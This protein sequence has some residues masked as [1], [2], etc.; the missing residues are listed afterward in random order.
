MKTPVNK[1]YLRST[2]E[3]QNT[4]ENPETISE[5][6]AEEPQQESDS[7]LDLSDI[8]NQVAEEDEQPE[9]FNMALNIHLTPFHG[10]P[11]DKAADWLPW[12]FNFCKAHNLNEERTQQMLQF[13][14]RDHALA[15]FSAQPNAIREDFNALTNALKV[16]FD[17]S[18]GLDSDIMLLSLKQNPTESVAAFFTRVLK[19]TTNRTYPE[20]LITSVAVQGLLPELKTIVMPHNHKTLEGLRQ[21]ATMAER[22]VA[23]TTGATSI[24]SAE[25]IADKVLQVVTARLDAVLALDPQRRPGDGNQS[26]S[27]PQQNDRHVPR[28]DNQNECF[29]CKGRITNFTYRCPAF[30][31]NCNYC[32]KKNHFEAA[33]I[34]KSRDQAKKS[35]Q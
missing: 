23:A 27:Q 22:T 30:G 31:K 15:W 35:N 3:E 19:C 9:D 34:Q 11:G 20:S 33:C 24:L 7:S 8:S 2:P 14:L 25:A 16:R 10:N 12:Y 18:D 29:R 4:T 6:E 13:Y 26:T 28:H 32:K 5:S 21:A 17:G 1:Y